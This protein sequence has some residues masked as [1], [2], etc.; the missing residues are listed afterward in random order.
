MPEPGSLRVM[1]TLYNIL[2]V[3]ETAS[4]QDIKTAFRTLARDKHPDMAQGA[5]DTD[6][7]FK[8]I[9]NAYSI[10]SNS[11]ERARYD[12]GDID[13]NGSPLNKS[14]NA[15]KASKSPYD[16]FDKRRHANLK[17]ETRNVRI[18]GSDVFYVL[19][20]EFLDG[21]NGAVKHISM[22]NGRR[23]RVSI[24]PGTKHKQVLRLKGQGVAGVGGGKN[25][26]ALVEILLKD[27]SLFRLEGNDII[28]EQPVSLKQAVLGGTLDVTGC[29]GEPITIE[30]PKNT[31]SGT[32]VRIQGKGMQDRSGE[33]GDQIVK[34]MVILPEKDD[35]ELTRFIQSWEP[36]DEEHDEAP[37]SATA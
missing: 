30:I 21:V 37:L 3:S 14:D 28:A 36:S 15:E 13:E 34:L 12:R 1:R 6:D 18:D 20:V 33:C 35:P 2:G 32:T 26:S 19:R 31:S 17:A 4:E 25:G 24:P 23:I 29:N 16:E 9:N 27:H 8:E 11:R 22:T 7:S 10:L 5:P